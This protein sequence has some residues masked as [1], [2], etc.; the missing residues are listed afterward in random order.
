MAQDGRAR[1]AEGRLATYLWTDAAVY[2][3][4][5]RS[6]SCRARPC[7]GVCEKR[8]SAERGERRHPPRGGVPRE[9]GRTARSRAEREEFKERVAREM[10]EAHKAILK[11]EGELRKKHR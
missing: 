7:R 4:E 10:G 2:G 9:G 6:L 5:S 11:L 8:R 3:A 1:A